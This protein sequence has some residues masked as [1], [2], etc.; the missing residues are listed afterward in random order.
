[1]LRKIT[2][3]KTDLTV[4]Q[5]CLGTNM[6]G[7]AQ[8]AESAQAIL[9][10]FFAG[11]G[12]FI[13]TAHSYGDWIPGGPRAASERVLGQLLKG[14]PRGSYVL[15]TK[16][17]EFDYRKGDWAPRVASAHLEADLS[18]S[19]EL[20]GVGVIDLYWLHRDDPGRPVKEIVDAL[21]A[22]QQAGR[23][24]HFGCSNWSVARIKEAQTYAASIGHAGFVACQPMWGL[25]EP[26][27]TAMMQ[28]AP[29]GYYEDG[30]RELH[31]GGLTM[32]PYSGQS[33]GIFSKLAAGLTKEAIAPD[34][35]ALYFNPA[36]QRK[37]A[38]LKAI[39]AGYGTSVN[40][41]V[42]AYMISQ[43]L[44]TVP[45]VGCSSVAQLQESMQAAAIALDADALRRLKEA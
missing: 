28:Y 41:I 27:R 33:R 44:P 9:D 18:Q 26:D 2:L 20:L 22:H 7:T 31:Q 37:V 24:R 39:A 13:D 15:A 32:I 10:A 25:A 30:Y 29:G 45:I 11:G 16:G 4:S 17:C 12:N 40:D 6:F 8:P 1:M 5:L 23:I 42:L 38:V 43:P 3:A 21:I 14:K 19:L 35:A 34:V 36:N